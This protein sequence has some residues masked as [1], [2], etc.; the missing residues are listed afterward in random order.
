MFPLGNQTVNDMIDIIFLYLGQQ[1]EQLILSAFHH[2]IAVPEGTAHAASELRHN[3]RPFFIIDVLSQRI[4]KQ[5]TISH[6][7]IT[8]HIPDHVPVYGTKR[9]FSHPHGIQRIIFF[10]NHTCDGVK[11]QL[12]IMRRL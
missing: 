10:L 11:I 9:F 1:K 7:V 12:P 8:A 3:H 6:A 5:H 4:G 2:D